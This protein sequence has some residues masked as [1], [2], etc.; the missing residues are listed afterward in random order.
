M[1]T[2]VEPLRGGKSQDMLYTSRP[3][4]VSAAQEAGYGKAGLVGY[5]KPAKEP[6]YQPPVLYTWQGGWEGEGWGHFFI[7]R[8]G[9]E[10]AMYWYYGEQKGQYYLGRYR[11]RPDG[12]RAEGV[13]YGPVGEKASFYRHQITFD[14]EA[15]SGPK[16][17]LSSWR[18]AAPL[19]D[20][21]MVRFKEPPPDRTSLAKA[22]QKLPAQAA[23]LLN[24]LLSGQEAD[25]AAVL[26]RT[27]GTSR[28]EGKLLER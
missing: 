25:P 13:A 12:R 17:E 6:D 1:A 15:A 19:D 21:R 22:A 14:T 20:G 16:A 3:E 27:L 9:G 28:S 5:L 4:T 8:Q 10:L 11:L 26:E 7:A 24:R 18:V 2:F 23:H